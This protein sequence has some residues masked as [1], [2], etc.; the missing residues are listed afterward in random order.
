V[1]RKRVLWSAK[2]LPAI[3]KKASDVAFSIE[4]YGDDGFNTGGGSTGQR[5]PATGRGDCTKAT[6]CSGGGGVELGVTGP[7][8]LSFPRERG[9]GDA[10]SGW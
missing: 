1:S 7:A 2:K 5:P 8:D 6:P 10:P 9:S 4:E 3:G